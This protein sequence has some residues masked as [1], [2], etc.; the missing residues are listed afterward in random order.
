MKIV[1]LSKTVIWSVIT[2]LLLSFYVYI[3][4]HLEYGLQSVFDEGFYYLQLKPDNVFT[5]QT[6]PLSLSGEVIRSI[7]SLE[8][9]WD[10]L[11]LRQAAFGI[12]AFGIV[13]LLVCSV[14]FIR[15]NNNSNQLQISSI[16]SLIATVLLTGLF[17]MPSMVIN[18]NDILLFLGMLVLSLCFLVVSSEKKW[19]KN[20][21]MVLIGFLA[22]FA[23]L[24]SVPGGFILLFLSFLFLVLFK[25]INKKKSLITIV[26]LFV[27]AVLGLLVMH[28][29]VISLQNAMD[30]LK[31]VLFQTTNGESSSH[32]SL[33]KIAIHTFLDIR[34]LVISLENVG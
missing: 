32:H 8:G 30:F 29:A 6:R 33:S 31:T 5:T 14:V 18:C 7:I 25:G 10:V 19:I 28:F 34:D 15:R 17:V 21:L 12:K 24:C 27:G 20:I 16:L 11:S 22:F 23:I 9:G 2:L 26:A 3:F 1:G 4:V 13:F